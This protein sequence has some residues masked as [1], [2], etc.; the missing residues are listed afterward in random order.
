M[1]KT[2]HE[3]LDEPGLPDLMIEGLALDSRKVGRG[4]LFAALKGAREDGLQYVPDAVARGARVI[5]LEKGAPRPAT[6]ALV[7]EGANARRLLARLAARFYDRQP[8][9][10]AAVTGTNGKSSVV[11]MFRQLATLVGHRAASIG[12]LGVNVDGVPRPF[13]LTT[14]DPITLHE[15]LARLADEGVSHAAFEASSHGLKQ[16]RVDGAR[17]QAAAF[18]NLSRDHLDYHETLEDYLY[19]KLRLVGE[20]LPPGATVVLNADSSFSAEFEAVAWARGMRIMTVGRRGSDITLLM[21]TARPG[22]QRLHLRVGRQEF[23]VDLPLIGEFQAANALVAAGLLI[24][25]GG[26]AA[27]VIPAL[28]R[29]NGV[30]GRLERVGTTPSGAEVIIDYAHT[31]DGLA[32]ALGALRPH[33][34]GRLHLVFGCGGDRDRGKRPQMGAIAAEF[35]G[36]VY[37]TDDNPRSEDPAAIRGDIIAACPSALEYDDRAAA[38]AAALAAAAAGDIVLIAG[39]GHETGQQVGGETLPFSDLEAARA[40]LAAMEGAA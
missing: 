13:G 15:A 1:A 12:T 5:L 32:N 23:G 3:L 35:A 40:A 10:L 25:L 26:R 31:P 17:L 27:Q 16:F 33:A 34:K 39:K 38:I 30:A 22:G 6:D 28:A 20:V 37:V 8:A 18:T 7:V 11:D 21:R 24:A 19:A 4:Y 29:L 14:P 2:L 9:H 36:R